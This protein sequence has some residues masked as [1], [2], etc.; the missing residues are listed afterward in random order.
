[1]GFAAG[2]TVDKVEARA[3]CRTGRQGHMKPMEVVRTRAAAPAAVTPPPTPP[4]AFGPFHLDP[5]DARLLRE[6]QSVPLT[7]KA[8]DVLRFLAGRPDRLVTKDE[9]LSAIWPDVIVTDA[10]VKVC[11]REIRKALGDESKTPQFI[12][13]VHRRGYRFI[14]PVRDYDAEARP[15]D[16][17]PAAGALPCA[18]ESFATTPGPAPALPITPRHP[19]VGRDVEM[20]QL[21]DR[22]GS[23]RRGV[24]QCVFITGGPGSGKTALVE[25]L[26]AGAGAGA[27][28]GADEPLFLAGHCFEQFGTSEPY[29][30]VWEALRRLPRGRTSAALAALLTRHAAAY[31]PA[32]D[33]GRAAPP[34]SL[35][36][37]E[38]RA[39]SDRMLRDMAEALESLAADA[40]VVLL[41]EDVHW[42][43]YS[44]LDL[45]SALARRGGPAR[46]LVVATYRPADALADGHPLRD[47]ARE[48][49]ARGLC[50][51]VPLEF[52]AEPAVG[53]YL[54]TRFPGGDFPAALARRLHQ[55]TDGHP[56]FLVH[57]VDELVE[58]GVLVEREGRW[59]LAGV[60]DGDADPAGG[61]GA[62]LAVLDTHIPRSAR[63][64]IE[65]H[66]ERLGEEEQR[67]LEAAA[68]AGVE[69]S[70][71]AAA[72]ALGEDVVRAERVCEELARG[73]RFLEPHGL[74]EWP[75]GTVATH[76]KFVH[77]LYHNAVHER[78]PVAR[79]VWL[80]RTL[81]LRLE[82]AFAGYAVEVAPELA[83]HFELGRDWPRALHHLRQAAAVASRH[84]AHREAVNYLRRA[85]AALDRSPAAA[86]A[87][88]ELALLKSLAVNLQVTRGFAAPEVREVHERAYTLCEA[89][90]AGGELDDRHRAGGRDTATTFPVLWGI[91]VF[92]KVRSDLGRAEEM[93]G[94]LL[95]L[96]REAGD[97]AL[98]LQAHQSMCVTHLCL[99]NPAV[100]VEHM[101]QAAAMYDPRRHA[102]N[103]EFFGQDPGVATLAFGSV[104]LWLMGRGD[105]AAAAG[106]R[107]VALA[108]RLAQPS[109]LA[110][111]LFFS[112]MLHQLRGDADVVAAL[113]DETM[114]LSAGE[115]FSFWLAGATVLRGWARAAG[116]DAGGGVEG[117]RRG[118][119]AWLATG[120]RTYHSY[121]LG[122]LA[123][124]LLRGGR[125][126]EA[127]AALDDGLATAR[128][129]REGLYLAELHRLKAVTL[130][131][132]PMGDGVDG[133]ARRAA[134]HLCRAVL[135]ARQ[136]RA[137]FFERLAAADLD[138]SHRLVAGTGP[139]DAHDLIA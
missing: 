122:L 18:A 14:A 98:M 16:T 92:H 116:G 81:G 84:Y 11:V 33:P 88:H 63:A 43:D 113:A 19:L 95:A 73:R 23:A 35:A 129:L 78:V 65:S 47:V 74:A 100:T 117:I 108:R 119:D 5:A 48:L 109:S 58:Q 136:Q 68:V 40:P 127:L 56:L 128:G 69:F 103:T 46:L 87:E 59:R 20:G 67:V 89:E 36:P 9:L 21:L 131:N 99:G 70:A 12:Q 82:E 24:R 79:R 49:L 71:A 17:R 138:A 25:A 91:W 44:T 114:E 22:L 90:A 57:L 31:A 97:P 7:P 26:V 107:S 52:L 45:I 54:A 38:P 3:T 96:A 30:P 111:A 27:G 4:I 83:M 135:I 120:S 72:G 137:T 86:R 133:V 75:D 112:A 139:Q 50:H 41:L 101:E 1:M 28:A 53:Q 110:V 80:H 61:D 6:G 62:W 93:A 76:Y 102:A 51:E 34:S 13:T 66:L 85:L 125:A 118:L 126:R 15:Q 10:S 130:R 55:R 124:A 60:W 132:F 134:Q 105:E 2:Q 123:D 104:A 37:S 39:G 106:E 42:A 29:M 64:M 94:R 121:F 115:G 32:T 8:F 77:E